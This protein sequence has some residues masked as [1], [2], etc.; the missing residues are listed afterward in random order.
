MTEFSF[1]KKSNNKLINDYKAS[2]PV[3]PMNAVYVFE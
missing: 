3:T 2:L 1:E